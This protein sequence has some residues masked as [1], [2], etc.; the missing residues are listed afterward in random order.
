MVVANNHTMTMDDIDIIKAIRQDNQIHI[1][2]YDN[3]TYRDFRGT[4]Y[5]L[6][7]FF[8]SEVGFPILIACL[9]SFITFKIK[10]Y[11]EKKK[12]ASSNHFKM[13]QIH[14]NIHRT[15][16][17]ERITIEGN[18]DDVLKILERLKSNDP[19]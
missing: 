19:S 18:A 3:L 10:A 8:V 7:T 11:T 5:N 15:K 12:K 9:S 17:E 6:A 1:L 4:E 13:P 16:K 14:I 2:N